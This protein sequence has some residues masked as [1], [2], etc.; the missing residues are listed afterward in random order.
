MPSRSS[1]STAAIVAA[2]SR[3]VASPCERSPDAGQG[4]GRSSRMC[5]CPG[6]PDAVVDGLLQDGSLPRDRLSEMTLQGG[7][8]AQK[9]LVGL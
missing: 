6:N 9:G 2:K 4:R 5:G 7:R 1:H 3:W 8:E